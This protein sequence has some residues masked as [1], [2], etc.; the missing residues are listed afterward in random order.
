MTDVKSTTPEIKPVVLD[1]N[2]PVTTPVEADGNK[3][4]PS[5]EAKR[6]ATKV[7]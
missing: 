4:T 6:E 1:P 7:A 5:L 2:K 3:V